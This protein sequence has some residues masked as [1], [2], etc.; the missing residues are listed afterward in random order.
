MLCCYMNRN[1]IVTT[2]KKL[3]IPLHALACRI[4]ELMVCEE[5]V[6]PKPAKK[7]I[8]SQPAH[9]NLKTYKHLRKQEKALD[10][11]INI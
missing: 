3:Y 8:A 7:S 1:V 4:Q 10:D 2:I 11:T 5:V 9:K 6:K